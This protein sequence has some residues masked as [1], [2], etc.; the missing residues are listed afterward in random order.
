MWGNVRIAELRGRGWTLLSIAEA[1]G[2]TEAGVGKA[3]KRLGGDPDT[4]EDG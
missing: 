4:S 3:V 1:L 2:M